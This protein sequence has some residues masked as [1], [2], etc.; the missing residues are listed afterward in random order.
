VQPALKMAVEPIFE[1][2]FRQGG[3][4]FRPGRGFQGC[5]PREVD[6]LIKEGFVHGVDADVKSY[7][8]A[9]PH[10]RL[11]ARVKESLSDGAIL[12]LIEGF[13]DQ[14][15]MTEMAILTADDGR[16][17]Q[18]A[19]PSPPPAVGR[20]GRRSSAGTR[21][22]GRSACEF[23]ADGKQ[24]LADLKD[25]LAQFGLSLHEGETRPI[26]FG[27]FAARNRAAA[28]RRRPET[29]DFLG[30]THDC[31]KTRTNRFTVKRKT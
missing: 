30:F 27:R 7:S 6:R 25:R 12:S 2:Q 5:G 3:Y 8:D 17:P 29:F 21:T 11:M 4:G 28:G 23:E 1:V 26:E 16:A 13:L 18:G 31:G 14:D 24:C 15:I 20:P 10:D 9:I 19:A 22:I